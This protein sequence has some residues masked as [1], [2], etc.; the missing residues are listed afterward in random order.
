MVRCISFYIFI[1]KRIFPTSTVALINVQFYKI[2]VAN[3][4]QAL[5]SEFPPPPPFELSSKHS[6]PIIIY[7]DRALNDNSTIR[8]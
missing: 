8:N 1:F 5:L 4:R 6:I 3:S 7:T 2:D